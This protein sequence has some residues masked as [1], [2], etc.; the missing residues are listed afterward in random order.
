M[1]FLPDHHSSATSVAPT[2]RGPPHGRVHRLHRITTCDDEPEPWRL[3]CLAERTRAVFR[4][5]ICD[6]C[7][8]FDGYDVKLGPGDTADEAFESFF[9]A[10]SSCTLHTSSEEATPEEEPTTS[11]LYSR[12]LPN[13][14]I[15]PELLNSPTNSDGYY[16]AS[17]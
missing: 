6:D 5:E 7:A 4:S 8:N 14:S 1:S 16:T 9:Y 12:R 15:P 17:R 2:H 3:P 10:S 13:R 11:K